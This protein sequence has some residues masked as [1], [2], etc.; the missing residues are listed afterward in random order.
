M[1]LERSAIDEAS[2]VNCVISG[3]IS[4]LSGQIL[5]SIKMT[6][7]NWN[8]VLTS[9]LIVDSLTGILAP[10][11]TFVDELVPSLPGSH[12]YYAIGDTGP[13]GG[14]V[15][16]SF[17]GHYMEAKGETGV[18]SWDNALELAKK[19][20]ASGFADWLIPTAYELD[21]IY[22]NIKIRNLGGFL[23]DYYWS[24]SLAHEYGYVFAWEQNFNNGLKDCFPSYTRL[25]HVVLIR[26]F[27]LDS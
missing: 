12:G 21:M 16:Y 25:S 10:I 6:E 2:N 26:Y 7:P 8:E 20:R 3:S 1:L 13:G 24:S 17:Y 19:S 15:F 9:T 22:Q 23:N 4:M 18:Y 14:T 27:A 5:I 11:Q